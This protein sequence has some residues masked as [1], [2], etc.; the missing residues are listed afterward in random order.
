MC[1]RFKKF[2]VFNLTRTLS[3]NIRE[4]VY[5]M[6]PYGVGDFELG[7]RKLARKYGLGGI[8]SIRVIRNSCDATYDIP[9]FI[10]EFRD[11]GEGRMCSD[12]SEKKWIGIHNYIAEVYEEWCGRQ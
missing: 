9:V 5:S 1:A 11:G 12:W 3:L 8:E 10:H 7:D 4:M 2:P 6:N